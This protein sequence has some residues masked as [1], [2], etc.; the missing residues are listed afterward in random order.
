MTAKEFKKFLS[1]I[2]DDAEIQYAEMIDIFI[3]I[4]KVRVKLK[5]QKN[6]VDKTETAEAVS[7]EE[8]K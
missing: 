2:P 6:Y 5:I 8:S 7:R 1:G 3:V 4:E